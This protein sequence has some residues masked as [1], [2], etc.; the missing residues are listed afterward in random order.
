MEP[1]HALQKKTTQKKNPQKNLSPEEWRKIWLEKLSSQIR[2][3][4]IPKE[5]TEKYQAN[6][7]KF[8]EKNPKAPKFIPVNDFIE[9]L[10]P[11]N[12]LALEAMLFFYKEIKDTEEY[13]LEIQRIQ[14]LNKLT[15]E[16]KLKNYTEST[17]K[18][19]RSI[20]K[21]FL[22]RIT[23]LPGKE[24]TNEAKQYILYLKDHKKLAP[25]TIN[26]A[27]AALSFFY[28]KVLG[29]SIMTDKI[30]RMKIGRSLPAV[31]SEID[32]QKILSAHDNLKHRSILYI[33]YGCGLRLNEI[34]LLKK[35]HIDFS[36]DLIKVV[37]GKGNK[38]RY[39][40]IDP[41]IRTLLE[42]YIKLYKPSNY[43]FDGIGKDTPLTK[44]TIGKIFDQACE[45]AKVQKKGGIHTLRHSFATH[46]LEHGTDLRCIQKLLGHA[47]STTTE[48]YTHVS[49]NMIQ[50]IK[51]PISNI[52]I[53]TVEKTNV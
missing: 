15:N 11:L 29:S 44:R 26:L 16:L 19:Y 7:Q 46:L 23:D 5:K 36:R 21:E 48:I 12:E 3:K 8:L 41:S 13:Q 25:R 53:L 20:V 31:Y 9:Y 28:E 32:I 43:L 1:S 18:N 35:S 34:R 39:V 30:P 33:A 40:M 10:T 52:I 6:I 17:Q 14:L 27:S 51:S 47:H 22:Y 37:S 38:D 4:S 24:S 50:K 45:K 42:Q 2:K 49:K